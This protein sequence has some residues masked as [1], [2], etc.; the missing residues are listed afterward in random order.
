[1]NP[2]TSVSKNVVPKKFVVV[3]AEPE[4]SK[5]MMNEKYRTM[6]TMLATKPMLS[7]PIIAARYKIVTLMS[8]TF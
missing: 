2:P 5:C 7:S 4:R 6:L 3:V 8:P 1:M